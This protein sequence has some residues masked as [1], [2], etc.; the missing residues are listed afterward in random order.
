MNIQIDAEIHMYARESLCDEL[1]DDSNPNYGILG[2]AN[3]KQLRKK[4]AFSIDFS[5]SENTTL[6]DVRLAISQEINCP[7]PVLE[8][9]FISGEKRYYIDDPNTNFKHL[10][11]KYFNPKS[12]KLSVYV[13]I[14]VDA[15]EICRDDGIRYCM[16]SHEGTK[17]NEAHVHVDIKGHGYAASVSILSGNILQGELPKKWH[18]KVKQKIEEN[19]LYFLDCWNT[20]TDGLRVDINKDFGLLNY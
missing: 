19:K 18:K 16:Y 20:K 8:L 15:G 1:L 6:G 2:E 9:A 3:I 11:I 10:L 4:K 12:D 13:F 5:Y 14:S 17:H 7:E